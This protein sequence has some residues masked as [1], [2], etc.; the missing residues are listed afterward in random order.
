MMALL[1][2]FRPRCWSVKYV[3]CSIPFLYILF[4]LLFD[5]PL[6]SSRLPKTTGPFP[7]VGTIDIEIPCEGHTSGVVNKEG[8]PAFEVSTVLFSLFYPTNEDAVSKTRHPWVP[9]PL[10]LRGE[11]YA[12]LAGINN[13]LMNRILTFGVW[14]LVGSTEIPAQVDTPIH[15]TVKTY[16]DYKAEHPID[17][18]YGRPKFPVIVFSHGV[19]GS[20]TDYTAYC[21]E[22][23]SRGII[24]AVIEHRDGSGPASVI[25]KDKSKTFRK[26]FHMTPDMLNPKPD[27]PEF[28][29]MQL[30]MRQREVEETVR[31]LKML[32]DGRGEEVFAAN[33][34]LEGKHLAEWKGRLDTDLFLVGGHSYGATLALQAL[35]G[36]PSEALPFVGGIMFDP[37]KQ[38]G[39]LN[40]DV[41]V[42]IVVVHSESWY[43][44]SGVIY[45]E[46]FANALL[47]GPPN[48]Q[49]SRAGLISR[50]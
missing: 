4:H 19:A 18:D 33:T 48:T 29:A 47:S 42:P 23:A 38:S 30:A 21:S 16:V 36:A 3:L 37:G 10:S 34:R 15:G 12:R 6:L 31:I 26:V 7:N 20:R 1:S 24:V 9:K 25:K 11:G 45:S 14:S 13:F 32:N 5:M 39:P 49:S 50:W 27:T 28:K 17:G 41:G 46:T 43:V 22:V 40:D 35:K 44:D 2:Y 8:E